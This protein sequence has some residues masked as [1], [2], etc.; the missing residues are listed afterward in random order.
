MANKSGWIL[1]LIIISTFFSCEEEADIPVFVTIDEPNIVEEPNQGISVH[2]IN[3]YFLFHRTSLLGGFSFGNEVPVLAEGIEDLL[4]FPGIRKNGLVAQPDIYQMMTSDTFRQDFLPGSQVNF[5]PT[6]RYKSNVN[7]SIVENFEGGHGFTD[8]VDNNANTAFRIENNV[9][10]NNS[11][12]GVMEVTRDNPI[13]EVAW[14]EPMTNLPLT[15]D[16]IVEV[17]HKNNIELGIG[18]L[19]I[20]QL[21]GQQQI[22]KVIL[23]PTSEW[24]KVYVDLAPEI[25]NSGADEVRLLIGATH[26]LSDTLGLGRA[27]IDD[28]KLLFLN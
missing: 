19:A 3:E 4:L 1:Y 8:D 9:G 21:N 2:A 13:L 26:D 20:S 7:F 25:R 22:Y 24:N 17:T 15:G 28:V 23:F 18:I 5:T 10:Y 11:T 27:L 6:F 12:A 14:L 16:I